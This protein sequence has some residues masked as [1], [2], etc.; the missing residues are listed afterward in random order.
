MNRLPFSDRTTC[1][2]ELAVFA[3]LGFAGVLM[4]ALATSQMARLVGGGDQIS[5][6]I[7]AASLTDSNRAV[8]T[9]V[10]GPA[11]SRTARGVYSLP[12]KCIAPS[13]PG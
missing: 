2:S 12:T 3:S 1:R 7:E 4:V 10:S 9:K 13:T 5:A 6:G 11:G 8:A